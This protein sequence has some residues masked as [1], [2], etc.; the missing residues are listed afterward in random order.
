[1]MHTLHELAQAGAVLSLMLF[2]FTLVGALAEWL[3]DRLPRND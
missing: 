2:V 3:A 1:M